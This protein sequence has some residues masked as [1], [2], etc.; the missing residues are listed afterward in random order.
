MSINVEVFSSPGCSK[1][2]HAK[3]VLKKVADEMGADAIQWRD[4][5]VLEELD[6]AVEMGILSTPAIV[7]DGALL[8]SSLPSTT[9]LHAELASRIDAKNR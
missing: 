7:I 9:K 6:Y 1:C 2:S 4:V 8:F 3:S 5:N